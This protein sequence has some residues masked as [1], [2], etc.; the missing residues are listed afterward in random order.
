[1]LCLVRGLHID[2]DQ[3]EVD[4]LGDLVL[5][6]LAHRNEY[7]A[8]R[9]S[10]HSIENKISVG[11]IRSSKVL[12]GGGLA[13]DCFGGE[14][15]LP[16]VGAASPHCL[17]FGDAF[18]SYWIGLGRP[19][20]APNWQLFADDLRRRRPPPKPNWRAFHRP[21]PHICRP[22][23]VHFPFLFEPFQLRLRRGSV[24]SFSRGRFME[25]FWDTIFCSLGKQYFIMG[26]LAIESSGL[27]F[28][29]FDTWILCHNDP[30]RSIGCLVHNLLWDSLLLCIFLESINNIHSPR[31]F[32]T[33]FGRSFTIQSSLVF[34]LRF[35]ASQF[36]KEWGGYRI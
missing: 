11:S 25:V 23:Q 30:S 8:S 1:M 14:F 22:T 33:S 29:S 15:T 31:S 18:L 2:E 27:S 16:G 34:P 5:S 28:W 13:L 32:G 26:L 20:P 36:V 3:D 4:L 12:E 10:T 35:T 17:P 9:L 24:L 19:P 7:I 21:S 6:L